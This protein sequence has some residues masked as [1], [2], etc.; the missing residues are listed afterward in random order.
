MIPARPSSFLKW[1]FGGHVER[2]VLRSFAALE[3]RGLARV[4][5]AAA[6]GPI[7]FV[8][9]H[10]A[11]WDPMLC[12]LL[13]TRLVPL[14]GYA[15][16]D[17]RN[18]R[19][20]PF[21]GRLGGFGVELDDAGDRS[22][23]V[24]YSTGLLNGPGRAV[25]IFCQGRERPV[26]ERPLEFKPGAAVVANRAPQATV[27]PV[28]LRYCFRHLEKP[29]FLVSIGEPVASSDEVETTRLGQERAV[30]IELERIEQFLRRPGPEHGFETVLRRRRSWAGRTLERALGLLTGGARSAARPLRS[31]P[32]HERESS[33]TRDGG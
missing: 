25:W 22:A 10:T 28:A 26:T 33:S 16:M 31:L 4:R 2:R 23:G 7:L 21:L 3:M 30:E 20:L 6:T 1:Y 24:D 8:S 27:L 32:R 13:S 29:Y 18:L 9:N 19:T 12:I 17:A 11:W 14:D 15:M 5:E